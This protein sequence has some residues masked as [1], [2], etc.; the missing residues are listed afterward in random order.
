MRVLTRAVTE[1]PGVYRE[2]RTTGVLVPMEPRIQGPIVLRAKAAGGIILAKTTMV[3]F[4]A[5]FAGSAFGA[6]RNAYDPTRDASGSSCGTG[7]AVTANFA[8]VGIGEELCVL[9]PGHERGIQ[10]AADVLDD[11]VLEDLD[12]AGVA[13]DADPR[14]VPGDRRCDP[15]V[16]GIAVRLDRLATG[17]GAGCRFF[18]VDGTARIGNVGFSGDAKAPT[19]RLR[20]RRKRT[21]SRRHSADALSRNEPVIRP[22]RIDDPCGR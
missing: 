5:G 17:S 3:E 12:V 10:H 14:D 16:L 18:F 22:P 9:L 7:I 21:I 1:L 19:I 13:V 2:G 4:A 11:V 15:R 20:C 8:T 6:C